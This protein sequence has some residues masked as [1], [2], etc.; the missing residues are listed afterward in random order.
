M[1][2]SANIRMHLTG[3]AIPTIT[4]PAS[5]NVPGMGGAYLKHRHPASSY[6]VVGVAAML[7][8]KDGKVTGPNV[9]VGGATAN[10]V[11]AKSVESALAGIEPT[12]ENLNAAAEQLNIDAILGDAY[13][14]AE[15]R[16][17]LAKVMAKWAIG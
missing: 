14:S 3:K 2:E 1:W 13:A 8:V 17:H 6:A 11:H 7:D 12:R 4:F 9:V 15:Y 16:A 10:P 5:G